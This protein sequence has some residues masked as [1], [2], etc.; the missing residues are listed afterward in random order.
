MSV[1]ITLGVNK[2]VGQPNF[3]SRGASCQIECELDGQLSPENLLRFQSTARQM[4]AACREAVEQELA[5]DDPRIEAHS[6][7]PASSSRL[8]QESP[9]L[10]T[11][12]EA[13]GANE[14]VSSK[15][16]RRQDELRRNDDTD[17]VQ[18]GPG[19]PTAK[20]N[21]RTGTNRGGC[22]SDTLNGRHAVDSM[23]SDVGSDMENLVNINYVSGANS[24]QK[25][26]VENTTDF[27]PNE[28]RLR[29]SE[30]FAEFD[31][32]AA[33]TESR[34]SPGGANRITERQLRTLYYLARRAGTNLYS[35]LRVRYQVRDPAQ[36]D[37]LTASRLIDQLSRKSPQTP[38]STAS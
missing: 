20:Q 10:S 34:E 6:T 37:R 30:E 23:P 31:Q 25:A 38:Q 22:N 8:N 3:G 28:R 15:F 1:K 26:S 11:Q 18:S 13:H 29:N 24:H 17:A 16:V 5:T 7:R 21:G 19:L 33:V 35:I 9:P 2:K 36:L 12:A 4:Y 14:G 27:H 32:E